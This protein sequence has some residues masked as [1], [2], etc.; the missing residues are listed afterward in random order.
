MG[1]GI[2][3]CGCLNTCPRPVN[4]LVTKIPIYFTRG[5]S[6]SPSPHARY[7]CYPRIFVGTSQIVISTGS[8]GSPSYGVK[9]LPLN[10]YPLVYRH[11]LLAQRKPK[12]CIPKQTKKPKTTLLFF[13]ME[14]IFD[15]TKSMILDFT[16]TNLKN[17]L[18]LGI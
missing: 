1:M 13:V 3:R 11:I 12:N 7:G 5:Y 2:R 10:Q 4:K 15:T 6:L 9:L 16:C 18:N 8:P 14:E 17:F